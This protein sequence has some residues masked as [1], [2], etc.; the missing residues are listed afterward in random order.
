MRAGELLRNVTTSEKGAHLIAGCWLALPLLATQ[1]PQRAA[2]LA[3]ADGLGRS[4]ILAMAA[5]GLDRLADSSLIWLLIAATIVLLV[6]RRLFP[7]AL[8]RHPGQGGEAADSTAQRLAR[9]LASVDG[10][11][12]QRSPRRIADDRGVRVEL[13]ALRWGRRL[14]AL[15]LAGLVS[16]LMWVQAQPAAEVLEIPLRQAGTSSTV[17]AWTA[18][19]GHLVPV[20]GARSVSCSRSDAG[21][22]CTFN[23]NGQSQSVLLAAG[24]PARVDGHQ[25]VWLANAA[26]ADQGSARLFWRPDQRPEALSWFAFDVSTDRMLKVDSLHANVTMLATR[27]SGPLVF[28]HRQADGKIGSFVQAAPELLPNGAPAARLQSPARVRLLMAPALPPPLL[29]V[30]V[31]LALVGALLLFAVPGIELEVSAV[32][33][34]VAV[35]ACNRPELLVAVQ[36]VAG[37]DG[38]SAGAA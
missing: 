5:L 23:V 18:D 33:G 27:R 14:A 9:A 13:G 11:G 16:V 26:D 28:G 15:A 31:I 38:A 12:G 4:D 30:L 32:D 19:A 24:S 21:L 2:P 37:A 29:A 3:T 7:P 10:D 20:D 35:R 36:A 17:A 25:V 1:L 34:R 8:V 6:A 22:G